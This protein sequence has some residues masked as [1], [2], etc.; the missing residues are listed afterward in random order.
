V[1]RRRI[2]VCNGTIDRCWS[3]NKET[4]IAHRDKIEEWTKEGRAQE[5]PI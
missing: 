4:D 1:G 2:E 5:G 3:R